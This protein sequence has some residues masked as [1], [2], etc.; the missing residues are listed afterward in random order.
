MARLAR[1]LSRQF[2]STPGVDQMSVFGSLAA[3]SPTFSTDIE[4]IQSLSQFLTGWYEAVIDGNS[5]AIQDMNALFLVLFYQLAYLFENGIAEWNSQTTYY[6]G[7]RVSSGMFVYVSLIDSNLN[8]ALTDTTKWALQDKRVRTTTAADTATVADRYIRA[9][10]TA[11]GFTQKLPS[12]G[13]VPAGFEISVKNVGSAGN[14]V[15]V[16]GNGA[17][18]DG[19]STLTLESTPT[20]ESYNFV[21]N[22]T[23]WDIY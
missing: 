2:G 22:G 5:P 1:K 3:G 15:T 6:T 9:N 16:D 20:L 18:M 4:N 11:G 14:Q 10:S 12:I 23:T 8:G 21:S 17:T 13:S 7:S 19:A